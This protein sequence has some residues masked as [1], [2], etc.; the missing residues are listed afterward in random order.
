MSAAIVLAV[1]AVVTVCVS[2][3]LSRL[4]RLAGFFFLIPVLA[5][6]C[7]GFLASSEPGPGHMYFRVAYVFGVL[8]SGST[9]VRVL[10]PGCCFLKHSG[11]KV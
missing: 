7:F 11:T 4:H 3:A 5:F 8:L 10:F 9:I 6:S 2:L 1:A